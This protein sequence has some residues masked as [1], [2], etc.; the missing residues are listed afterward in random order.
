MQPINTAADPK[1]VF[2]TSFG[3]WKQNMGQLVIL[4]LLLLL[5]CWIP[6]VNLVLC[7]GYVRC[8][9][10]LCRGE[11]FETADMFR[12][13]DCFVPLLTYAVILVL[14]SILLSIIPIV[15]IPVASVLSAI[16]MPG[17]IAVTEHRLGAIDAFKWS[18]NTLLDDPVGWLIALVLSSV[19]SS[20]GALFFGLGA[21]FT[22]PL[23][24]II[25]TSQYLKHLPVI[26]VKQ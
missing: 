4:T 24:A 18:F 6:L 13:W 5:L 9:L 11:Q 17:F 21:L 22:L 14:A 19:L 20:L 3:L 1:S 26:Q 15:G 12:A 8:I 10:R 23:A 7:A 2:M 16:A 25:Y